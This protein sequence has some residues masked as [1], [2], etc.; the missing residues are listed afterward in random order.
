MAATA[1]RSHYDTIAALRNVP[2]WLKLVLLL[3]LPLPLLL[4]ACG[5]AWSTTTTPNSPPARLGWQ[6][7]GGFENCPSTIAARR[8]AV[9]CDSALPVAA[10]W[11]FRACR[12][13]QNAEE[14]VRQSDNKAYRRACPPSAA[15]CLSGDTQS[16]KQSS[17]GG[18]ASGLLA[19][20]TYLVCRNRLGSSLPL[21][22][23]KCSTV[24]QLRGSSSLCQDDLTCL[25]LLFYI[26]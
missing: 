14:L 9:A 4:L 15:P 17:P 18:G 19:S 26:S 6:R 13:Y 10:C 12:A 8:Q 3:L 7:K 23:G 21:R 1:N 16:T 22:P 24:G 20:R 5:L 11:R 2:S 25:C